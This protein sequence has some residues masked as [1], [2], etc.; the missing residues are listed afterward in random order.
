MIMWVIDSIGCRMWNNFDRKSSRSTKN[1][2]VIM[3]LLLLVVCIS[4]VVDLT[5]PTVM[6]MGTEVGI[7][8]EEVVG[9]ADHHVVEVEAVGLVSSVLFLSILTKLL[10]F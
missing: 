5:D 6:L 4:L 9:A 7:V 8:A 2:A 3:V 1:C 10:I